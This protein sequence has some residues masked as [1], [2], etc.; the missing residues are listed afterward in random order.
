MTSEQQVGEIKRKHSARLL[1]EPGVCG[2]GVERDENGEF[3]LAI[4]LD[5]A[6]PQAGST[7]PDSLDGCV[8]RKHF[9]GPFTKQ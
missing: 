9:D 6:Q 4:H 8:V 2:V 3:V 5:A 7:I 1:R